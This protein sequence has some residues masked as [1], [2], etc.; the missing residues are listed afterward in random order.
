MWWWGIL[1]TFSFLLMVPLG[2]IAVAFERK[3]R[4]VR[5][6]VSEESAS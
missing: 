1:L 5:D 3:R 4:S 6:G 2:F